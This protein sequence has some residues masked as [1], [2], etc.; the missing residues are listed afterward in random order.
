MALGGDDAVHHASGLVLRRRF[1]DVERSHARA[2]ELCQQVGETPQLFPVLSKQT[3]VVIFSTG[4]EDGPG[5]VDILARLL[6]P[7]P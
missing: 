4:Y 6:R 1:A 3:V 2:R 5:L 7:E